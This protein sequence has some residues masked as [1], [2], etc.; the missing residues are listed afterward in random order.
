MTNLEE[1]AAV[2]G[3]MTMDQKKLYVFKLN[4]NGVYEEQNAV[5]LAGS[6]EEAMRLLTEDQARRNAHPVKYEDGHKL[7]DPSVGYFHNLHKA[8]SDTEL[9]V[10]TT[11]S[12]VYTYGVDG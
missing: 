1:T 4:P 8:T 11:S 12:V 10:E 2:R 5:V 7:N 3:M 9:V 6:A